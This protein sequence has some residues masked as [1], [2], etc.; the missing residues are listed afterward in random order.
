MK[1]AFPRVCL[2]SLV[3][4][5]LTACSSTGAPIS[6]AGATAA[7]QANFTSWGAS[8]APGKTLVAAGD[9]Q[10]GTYTYDVANNRVTARTIGAQEPGAVLTLKFTETIP[11]LS[12]FW[13]SEAR[14]QTAS[15]TDISFN[16]VNDTFFTPTGS[17]FSKYVGFVSADQTKRIVIAETDNFDYQTYG[18]WITGIG[19]ASGTYGATSVGSPSPAAAVPAAGLATYLGHAGGRYVDGTGSVFF[20]TAAMTTSVDFF[21]REVYF[22][23]ST[24][25]LTQNLAALGG[26][27]FNNTLN[28]NGTLIIIAGTNQFSGPVSAPGSGMTG[29]ATGRFYGP[30]IQEI[31]GTFSVTGTGVQSYSGAF[32]GV[33]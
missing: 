32:G 20:A 27:T 14:F 17:G 5:G 9:S 19:T 24:T 4:A 1:T 31:G 15:G 26:S 10:Q 11:V 23:T 22:N 7:V 2:A 12:N 13:T 25:E 28:M 6:A 3:A 30:A 16:R 33:K 8:I 18:F 29:T 21:K